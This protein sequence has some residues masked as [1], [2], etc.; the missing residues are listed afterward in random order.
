MRI[1]GK[2]KSWD[3]IRWG[4]TDKPEGRNRYFFQPHVS[5]LMPLPTQP[6][7]NSHPSRRQRRWDWLLV[8]L[9]NDEDD[10]EKGFRKLCL[11]HDR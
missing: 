1:K 6:F 4:L 8:D 5:G 7:A 9:P 10:E 11:V 2:K 3:L